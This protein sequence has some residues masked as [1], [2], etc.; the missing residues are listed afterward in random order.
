M[1]V[2]GDTLSEIGQSAF[3]LPGGKGESEFVWAVRSQVSRS[4]PNPFYRFKNNASMWRHSK[5]RRSSKPPFVGLLALCVLAASNMQRDWTRGIGV[6]NYYT[7]LNELLGFDGRSEPPSFWETRSYWDD[8]KRWLHLDNHGELGL[9]TA[10]KLG[11]LTWIGHHI[12]QSLL[13]AAD[14]DKLPD[15]F[16]FARI[17]P[18]AEIDP[19]DLLPLLRRW[20]ERATCSLSGR[21]RAVIRNGGNEVCLHIAGI[22]AQEARWW[23]GEKEDIQGRLVSRIVLQI[24]PDRGGREFS[25]QFFPRRPAGF[26]SGNFT[27]AT[28]SYYL[29]PLDVGLEWYEPLPFSAHTYLSQSFELANGKYVLRWDASPLIV[30][31]PNM[32]LGGYTSQFEVRPDK[33]HL[34]LCKSYLTA[35]LEL[36]LRIYATQGWYQA[37]G[38]QGLPEGWLAYINVE[39]K[40]RPTPLRPEFACLVPAL[41]LSFSLKGGL[42]L[43][44]ATWLVG[45]EPKVEVTTERP[46]GLELSIDGKRLLSI[47][48]ESAEL[49]LSKLG[50]KA[51]SHTVTVG[52]RTRNFQNCHSGDFA[53]SSSYH[54]PTQCLAHV[55]VRRGNQFEPTF[56]SPCLCDVD[57][58]PPGQLRIIGATITGRA[59]DLPE[60]MPAPLLLLGGARKYVLL[61]PQPGMLYE[62]SDPGAP[63]FSFFRMPGRP[64]FFEA[65]PPFVPTWLVRV[66]WRHHLHLRLIG[67]PVPPAKEVYVIGEPLQAWVRWITKRYRE[68]LTGET[69]RLLQEYVQIARSL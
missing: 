36:F 47:S 34:L 54:R 17:P 11:R 3:S 46:M 38:T 49:D 48:R 4:S 12:S 27:S 30:A 64:S 33:K 29:Q 57:A 41:P 45:A 26:P 32:D 6:N 42:K 25:L 59:E 7:R 53:L 68:A 63:P 67:K 19:E 69:A 20:C 62:C 58:S 37:P 65:T 60:N 18:N 9:C 51:G 50:L 52:G 28:G 14:R 39:I 16:E 43:D 10:E 23:A 21:A 2:D 40:G 8:L 15:F 35:D 24:E 13:K 31:S 55:L 22:V 44:A 56:P 66:S 5:E 1:Q 61:G